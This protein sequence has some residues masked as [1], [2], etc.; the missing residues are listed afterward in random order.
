MQHAKNN[1]KGLYSSG[2]ELLNPSMKLLNPGIKLLESLNG[3]TDF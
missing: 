2:I 1:E 3:I